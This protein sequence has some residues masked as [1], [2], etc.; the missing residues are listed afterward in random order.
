[1]RLSRKVSFIVNKN[2]QKDS[3]G[4]TDCETVSLSS[5]GARESEHLSAPV[6]ARS[7]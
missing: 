4:I 2:F 7:E 3:L 5:T 6:K 1:M